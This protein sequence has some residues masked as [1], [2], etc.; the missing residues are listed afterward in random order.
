MPELDG[1]VALVTGASRGI[2]RAIALELAAAGAAVGVNYRADRDSAEKTVAS[3]EE[4]GGQA[5]AL[6]ECA[7]EMQRSQIHQRREAAE[8]VVAENRRV[9][10][11]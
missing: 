9:R 6:D 7:R 2:G 8:R 11:G 10:A 5:G 4:Y 3:I 1:R